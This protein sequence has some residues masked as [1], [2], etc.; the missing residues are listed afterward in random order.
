M[1]LIITDFAYTHA[2]Q[3]INYLGI[4]HR[5]PSILPTLALLLL[6]YQMGRVPWLQE[7]EEVAIPSLP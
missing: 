2:V 1:Q 4:S 3:C 7:V 5:R 6:T